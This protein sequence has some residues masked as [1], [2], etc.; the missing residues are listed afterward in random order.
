MTHVGL[1]PHR[2]FLFLCR[3][4]NLFLESLGVLFRKVF[5][6]LERIKKVLPHFFFLSMILLLT[7][8]VL[9]F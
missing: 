7:L 3:S 2:Q 5:S 9:I 6:S 4:M 8:N 1:F